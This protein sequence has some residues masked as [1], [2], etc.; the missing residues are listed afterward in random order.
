MTRSA[1]T[2]PGILRPEVHTHNTHMCAQYTQTTHLNRLVLP[3]QPTDMCSK[4][5]F[6]IAKLK[7]MNLTKF[8]VDMVW[9]STCE[10]SG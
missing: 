5:S 6:C 1:K 4:T 2:L 9:I 8:G 3:I 7:S 10:R